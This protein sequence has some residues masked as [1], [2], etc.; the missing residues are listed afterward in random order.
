MKTYKKI[1]QYKDAI[2]GLIMKY[3][4][5]GLDDDKRPIYDKTKELPVVGFVGT[6]KLHGTNAGIEVVIDEHDTAWST[7]Q[8]R[9]RVLTAHSDHYG[10]VQWFKE[11]KEALEQKA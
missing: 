5:A 9:G 1:K 10:F 6:P 2:K 3:Q 11:N 4:Y 8:S 7:P